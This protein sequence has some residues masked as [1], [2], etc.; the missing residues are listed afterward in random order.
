MNPNALG[1]I[2][3]SAVCL[4]LLF[5][6]GVVFRQP[7]IMVLAILTVATCYCSYGFQVYEARG[8][9]IGFVIISNTLGAMALLLLVL[10]VF[11]VVRAG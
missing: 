4:V 9:A 8:A 10:R 2:I 7:I 3:N 6:A 11:V 5:A 1:A